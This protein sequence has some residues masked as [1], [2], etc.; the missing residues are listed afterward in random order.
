MQYRYIAIEGNIGAGKT[1]LAKLLA[2]HY[3]ARLLLE[4]YANNSLLPKFYAEPERY[5]FQLELSFLADRYKQMK[6]VLLSPDLFRDSVVSDYLFLKSKLFAHQNLQEDEYNLF[7]K[8]FDIMETA[9]PQPDLLIYLQS[10]ITVLQEHIKQRGRSYEQGIEDSYLEGIESAYNEYI[11]KSGQKT[12]IV[13]IANV[14]FT[15]NISQ[16][17]Q[18]LDFLNS[19]YTFTTYQL[20]IN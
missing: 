14:N 12:L 4:E 11:A 7:R 18:L 17:Q 16:F 20:H 1:T 13:D 8:L 10:P 9:L 15:S 6:D 5:A 19:D 2:E 3:N